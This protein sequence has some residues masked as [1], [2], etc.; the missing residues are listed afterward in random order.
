MT[1]I[2]L[3]CDLDLNLFADDSYFSYSSSSPQI[4]EQKINSEMNKVLVWLNINKLTI[5]LNKTSY[6]I[7]TK[8]KINYDFNICFGNQQ[9]SRCSHASYLG[10]IID[11]KLNWKF[12]TQHVRKKVVSGCWALH[13]VKP[14][15]NLPTLRKIYF[16]LVYPALQYC[17]S[18]W[19]HASKCHLEPL[20]VLNRRAVRTLCSAPWDA[21]TSPL[22]YK[23][24]I[25]KLQDIYK[26]QISK[27][28]HQIHN[29]NYKGDHNLT[30]TNQVHQYSTRFSNN[31]NYFRHSTTLGITDQAL[32]TIGPKIW[33][34]I[35][36]DIKC[37][38]YEPFVLKYKQHL[39]SKYNVCQRI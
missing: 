9:I 23:H 5:N 39:I 33:S 18:S 19:G 14:F 31:A 36:S 10:V 2:Y 7:V 21:H 34:E 25:L 8:K 29:N 30:L 15:V 32:G 11:D 26:L 6:M 24:N 3:S 28:I 27:I 37:L 35:P 20:N 22:F 16:G 13:K 1:R 17:I 12:H 38:R 4:L